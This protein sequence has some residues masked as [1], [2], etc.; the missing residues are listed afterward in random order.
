[1]TK[2]IAVQVM[3]IAMCMGLANMLTTVAQ[4]QPQD[5]KMQSG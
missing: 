3:T 5:E 1:M 4:A 2:R